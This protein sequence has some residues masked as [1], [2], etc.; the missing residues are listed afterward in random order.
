VWYV[1]SPPVTVTIAV[2]V[3]PSFGSHRCQ[4]GEE[5]RR[6]FITVLVS[7]AIESI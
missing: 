5:V 1:R 6:T 3:T 7:N 2:A 4:N